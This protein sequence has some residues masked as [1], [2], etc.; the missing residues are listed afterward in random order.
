M[1]EFLRDWAEQLAVDPAA[2]VDGVLTGRTARGT[3]QR[4]EA[5]DF[6]V[7]A[8]AQAQA[9]ED[10]ERLHALFDQGLLAWLEARR[11]WEPGR[12]A[13]FGAGAYIAQVDRALVTVTRLR[14]A[15]TAQSL[16][17]DHLSWE[18]W[19]TPL[20]RRDWIDLVDAYDLALA[21]N[22]NDTRFVARWFDRIAD[23]AAWCGPGWHRAL[24][25]GLIGLRKLP[26]PPGSQPEARVA[27]G[28][29]QFARHALEHHVLAEAEYRRVF[30]REA[31]ALT[32]LYPRNPEHWRT[33]WEGVLGQITDAGHP[34]VCNWLGER[35]AALGLI[36][37]STPPA[38]A[39]RVP[40]PP[41][42]ARRQP[43]QPSLPSRA[44]LNALVA[45]FNRRGFSPELWTNIREFVARHW[46]YAE[47]SGESHFV[48]RTVSNLGHRLLHARPQ[49]EVVISVRDWAVRALALEPDQPYI[50]D[51]WAKALNALGRDEDALAVQW[52]TVRRFPDNPV[53]RNRLAEA[54]QVRR[55]AALA[56]A[57]LRDTVRDFPRDVVCR[58]ALADLWRAAGRLDEAESLLRDTVRDFPNN[59]ICRTT[60][61]EVLR[62]TKQ[63]KHLKE[64][65]NILRDTVRDFPD[66]EICRNALADLWR[67][68]GRLDEAESLLARTRKR[69]SRDVVCRVLLASVYARQA[70]LAHGKA[71]AL[72]RLDKAR[73]AIG[74]A[75]R[76]DPRNSF[77]LEQK[78]IVDALAA[79][80]ESEQD[81]V[82]PSLREVDSV[83]EASEPSFLGM[84]LAMLRR[85]PIGE[86]EDGGYPAVDMEATE[87]EPH[88]GEAASLP[89]DAPESSSAGEPSSDQAQSHA[90][91]A[92]QTAGEEEY[93]S[94]VEGFLRL[95]TTH[96]WGYAAW[97][98]EERGLEEEVQREPGVRGELGAVLGCLANDSEGVFIAAPGV[99]LIEAQPGSYSLRLLAACARERTAPSE[100]AT[101]ADNLDTLAESFPEYRDWHDWLRLA[102]LSAPRRAELLDTVRP[103][104]PHTER[105]ERLGFWGG[106]LLAL[107]PALDNG[108]RGAASPGDLQPKPAAFRRL[109][110]DLALA[111][112][113]RSRPSV[114]SGCD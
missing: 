17:S 22:Q 79:Q 78:T 5:D 100:S 98:A 105:M 44:E 71:K 45:Q 84:S 54:L 77:T 49:R 76:L 93:E 47:A 62:E 66:D 35:L 65:E 2:A 20:R 90:S 85:T 86:L 19:L 56:E 104:G 43:S 75:L 88:A 92:V 31:A 95:N 55:R 63:P 48:V 3:L 101:S 58:V 60:L 41:I 11:D 1:S 30:E 67:A 107:Y 33:V 38:L 110:A 40:S 103:R 111:C 18:E 99:D 80:L 9:G 37:S 70:R 113:A 61:A 4:A 6:F 96:G 24:R 94:E 15:R 26:H 97:Y 23:A 7:A 83:D 72:D 64:A 28:L 106:R 46:R 16:A 29:A 68:A 32:T 102:S 74:E 109:A 39:Q 112:A 8:L 36:P 57:V 50:W 34:R 25:T 51:L 81:T 10:R 53:P 14:P 108:K 69:F 27:A 87:I 12:I 73:A 82:P 91:P 21:A 59:E 89:V 13:R 52:E 42:A 114:S